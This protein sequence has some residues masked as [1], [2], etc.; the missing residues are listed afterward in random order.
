MKKKI[1]GI[2]VCMLVMAIAVPAVESLNNTTKYSM[3][4]IIQQTGIAG[5]WTE[6]QKFTALDATAEDYFGFSLSCS[7]DTAFIGTPGDG[8]YGYHSGSVYVFNRIGATWIQ[9]Q[10]LYASDAAT[11]DAFGFSV[12]LDGDI[13]LVSAPR[14]DNCKG[15]VYV[16]T[17]TGTT[18]TQQTKLLA[19]DGAADDWFGYSVSLD[20]ENALI[21]AYHDD[22]NHGSA[23]VFTWDG[24]S[25]IQIQKLYGTESGDIR[26][27]Y[28]VS[29]DGDSALIGAI[30][31]SPYGA[32][33]VFTHPSVDWQFQQ[34]FS[35][36]NTT[37]LFG[38][39]VS[40]DGDSA[41]IGACGDYTNGFISGAAFVF[42]RTGT[43]WSEQQKLL[44]SDGAAEDWFGESICL[45]GDTVFIAAPY[46]D[47]NGVDSGSMY[48]FTSTGTTWAQQT[49][50]HASDGAAGDWFG[51]AVSLDG[52]TALIGARYDDDTIY[53][54]G[55]VYVFTTDGGLPGVTFT[56]TGGLGVNLKITN[57][58][59]PKSTDLTWHINV[60]GGILGKISKIS[61][62]TIEVPVGESRTVGTGLFFG[63]G[64]IAITAQ[65]ADEEKT[66]TGIQFIIFSMVKK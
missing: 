16:F 17:R 58:G 12:S 11:E 21:G 43:L 55:S 30:Y 49:K 38:S 28:S 31:E 50:L 24:A 37:G 51:N 48:V 59:T 20:G 64:P 65:V 29:L 35:A 36:S 56:I 1:I 66:A 23:Y 42:T 27:G 34:K 53:D 3:V 2:V 4:P 60:T 52:D 9:Q 8:E 15:A 54:S 45:H 14:D 41:L 63:L 40:L 13:A 44:P 57:N 10:K 6:I 61:Q 18:W 32:A 19:S 33:Y 39:S 62:G 25:W 22:N 26:F 47:D 46:D 7:G 5:N